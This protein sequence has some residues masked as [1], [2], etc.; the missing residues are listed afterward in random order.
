MPWDEHDVSNKG[1]T[2]KGD[3]FRRIGYSL[4]LLLFYF[5]IVGNINTIL[6]GL[7]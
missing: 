6:K 5:D 7:G 4:S 3:S 2:E 1:Y